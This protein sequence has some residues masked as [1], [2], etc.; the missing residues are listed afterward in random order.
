MLGYMVR[1]GV[2]AFFNPDP[3]NISIVLF[4][5]VMILL[6]INRGQYAAIGIIGWAI[7]FLTKNSISL[8]AMLLEHGHNE[9]VNID[10]YG[11]ISP[12]IK[13]GI[14]ICLWII[15]VKVSFISK[16]G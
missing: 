3:A 2:G 9:F 5:L 11:I 4:Q 6:V 14:A 13:I 8:I 7:I 16:K 12:F 15:A 1:D 10:I